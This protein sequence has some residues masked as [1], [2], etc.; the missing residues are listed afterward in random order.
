MDIRKD[1]DSWSNEIDR[2][3]LQ[4]LKIQSLLMRVLGLILTPNFCVLT[5]AGFATM[6]D[7]PELVYCL[8]ALAFTAGSLYMTIRGF[9]LKKLIDLYPVYAIHLTRNHSGKI[10]HA[11]ESMGE[12]EDAFRKT[13]FAMKRHGLMSALELDVDSYR[14]T[15]AASAP[16]Q[17]PERYDVVKCP[18]CGATSRLE[19]G[20]VD[21][22]RYCG[23]YLSSDE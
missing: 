4:R 18:S 3:V 22:C 9:K 5:L 19:A 16:Q 17:Q 12:N 10:A 11:A 15:G 8:I 1:T 13:L 2:G 23:A 20:T 7:M 21:E 14:M 6:D